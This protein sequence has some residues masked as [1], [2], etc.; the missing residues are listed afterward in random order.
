MSYVRNNLIAGE[1]I[2]HEG[3]LSRWIYFIPGLTLLFG[4]FTN[5]FA[6]NLYSPVFLLMTLP[7]S[8][9]GGLRLLNAFI[10]RWTTEF[11][12]TNK[13]VIGKTGLIQRNSIE[14]RLDRIE[15]IMVHQSIGGRLL[16][17]GDIGVKGSGGTVDSMSG[18][19][20]PML[21]RK[22]FMEALDAYQHG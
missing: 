11:S 20:D 6:D 9:T 14:V 21:I 12:V 5:L 15:S 19:D 16:G 13:R 22:K 1:I 4:L 3:K 2:I 17:Y 7:L 10:L 18:F 8:L